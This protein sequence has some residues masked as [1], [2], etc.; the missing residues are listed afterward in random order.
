[1]WGRNYLDAAVKSAKKG[2]LYKKGKTERVLLGRGPVLKTAHQWTKSCGDEV[3]LTEEKE[4][5]V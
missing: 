2:N 5:G 3:L 4:N 1:V